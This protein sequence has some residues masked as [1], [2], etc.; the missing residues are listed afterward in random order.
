MRVVYFALIFFSSTVHSQGTWDPRASIPAAGRQ[1]AFAFEVGGFGYIGTGNYAP[2][3]VYLSDMW[4][5]NPSANAWI[6]KA[7]YPVV[8]SRAV[9]TVVNGIAYVGTGYVNGTNVNSWYSYDPVA[10]QWTPKASFP[11]T[12]RQDAIAV[13]LNGKVYV[14]G[15]VFSTNPNVFQDFWEYNPTTNTWVQKGNLPSPRAFATEFVINNKAYMVG[16]TLGPGSFTNQV[17]EYDPASDTWTPKAPF[18]I[19]AN[20]LTS[21]AIN[22]KGYVGLGSSGGIQQTQWYEYDPVLDQWQQVASFAATSRVQTTGFS[23]GNA[24]YVATGRDP[25]GN[26]LNDFWRFTPPNPTGIQEAHESTIKIVPNPA[27]DLIRIQSDI[28]Y[29]E[30][31]LFD[32]QG[33][34]LLMR[35]GAFES[36]TVIDVS[37]I[38]SGTYFLLISGST[39][40]HTLKVVLE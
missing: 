31:R 6:Q 19:T 16:G 18:P 1:S 28:V 2:G 11:G 4:S 17:H 13:S 39:G 40:S 32:L 20:E 26:Y 15:G 29:N 37:D 27:T 7:S 36:E 21:F 14:G 25:G 38:T 3:P 33:R 23:I 12:A 34:M 10:D 5:Y 30:I 8:V 22:G 24:G 9:A 35:Q